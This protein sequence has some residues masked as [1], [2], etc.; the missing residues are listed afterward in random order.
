MTEKILMLNTFIV[1]YPRLITWLGIVLLIFL[2]VF[3]HREKLK[4][5][6]KEWKLKKLLKNI[7]LKCL[8]NVIIPDGIDGHI[9]IEYLILMPNEMFILAVKK[10]RGLIFAAEHIDLWTQVIGNKSYKFENPLQQLEINVVFLNSNLETSKL[11]KKVL[12]IKGCEFPKGKPE[13]IIS[14]TEVKQWQREQIKESVTAAIQ[15]DWD[16]LVS[17]S[18]TDGFV[19]EPKML[20]ASSTLIWRNV[21]SVFSFVIAIFLWLLWRLT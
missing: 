20:M 11:G 18:V 9:F 13:N 5:Y 19:K 16:T 10:F 4:E 17:L 3:L 2:S 12:F 14:I 15:K 7:G 1:D 21:F 6:I 8:H